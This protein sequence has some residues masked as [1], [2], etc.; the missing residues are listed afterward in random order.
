MYD[1]GARFYMPDIG[2]WGVIDPLAEVSR[3]WSPYNYAYN[4][5][6]NFV[7]PDGMLSVSSLQQM[8]DNTSQSSTW[9]NSRNGSFDGGEDPGPKTIF[10]NGY[11]MLGSLKGGR[12]Y[13]NEEFINGAK[14][15]GAKSLV[16]I[17]KMKSKFVNYDPNMGSSANSRNEEGYEYAKTNYASITSGMNSKEDYFN[18]VDHSMGA[19]FGEGMSKYLQEMG[20]SINKVVHLNAFQAKDIDVSIP[21]KHSIVSLN[22]TQI[23]DYQNTDDP[24]IS[25]PVRSSP[26]DIK[27]ATYSVREVSGMPYSYKH[28]SPI[29]KRENFWKSLNGKLQKK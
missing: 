9:S 19:A 22:T 26:G 20:W 5:P 18:I 28:A 29:S 11:L 25:N 16:D 3:K 6:I 7:D 8:W 13:W 2:R 24:M 27:N 12:E 21:K 1:Y 14:T 10:I 4:N 23:I 15:F 17:G